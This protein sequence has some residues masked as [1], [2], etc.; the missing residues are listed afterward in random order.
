MWVKAL[1]WFLLIIGI[2]FGIG[3]MFSRGGNFLARLYFYFIAGAIA[4][5]GLYLI[6]LHRP[7]P[8]APNAEEEKLSDQCKQDLVAKSERELLNIWKKG[9]KKQY[10]EEQLEAVRQ[11]LNERGHAFRMR[12]Q[13]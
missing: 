12:K 2:L 6:R 8:T 1:G 13:K 3:T 11:I 9:D 10:S 4:G 7:V 5:A